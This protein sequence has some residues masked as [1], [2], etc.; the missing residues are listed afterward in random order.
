MYN[1]S[2]IVNLQIFNEK[3]YLFYENGDIYVMGDNQAK[4][5]MQTKMQII[6]GQLIGKK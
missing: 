1:E 6:K 3:L 4:R 2:T 5:H